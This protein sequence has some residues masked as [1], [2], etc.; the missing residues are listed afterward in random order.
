M[1]SQIPQ[2]V[3]VWRTALLIALVISDSVLSSTSSAHLGHK[4][5]SSSTQSQ[6]VNQ[7]GDMAAVDDRGTEQS[8]F[9]RIANNIRLLQLRGFK[10]SNTS[11]QQL[12]DYANLNT[13]QNGNKIEDLNKKW[14]KNGVRVW[15]KRYHAGEETSSGERN[16]K[17]NKNG[18]RVWGKRHGGEYGQDSKVVDNRGE[19][20]D[21]QM[22]AGTQMKRRE[23]VQNEKKWN[24]N[25]VRVWGK[26]S[27]EDG[28]NIHK[29]WNKYGVRVWG[30][31]NP[32]EVENIEGNALE[33]L[34]ES[35]ETVKK[36]N[37]NGVK[38]WG[39]RTPIDGI[40]KE[41]KEEE[42][43]LQ[44]KQYNQNNMNWDKQAKLNSVV[45]EA[46]KKWN[47]NGVRVWGKR[48]EDI[49]SE[50]KKKR[51]GDKF[52]NLSE[53]AGVSPDQTG[54]IEARLNELGATSSSDKST[55]KDDLSEIQKFASLDEND[56]RLENSKRKWDNNKVRIWGKRNEE[57]MRGL[58]EDNEPLLIK[59]SKDHRRPTDRLISDHVPAA[60]VDQT[61]N[62]N[63]LYR[64][65]TASLMLIA[66]NPVRATNDGG[67]SGVRQVTRGRELDLPTTPSESSLPQLRRR[68]RAWRGDVGWV[69]KRARSV[70]S[71]YNL[72]EGPK[73][74]W[75]T[76]VI[77]VWGKRSG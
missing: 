62:R 4:P 54:D 12:A 9:S 28:S 72:P 38:V 26:R 24:K 2:Q 48:D 59:S 6:A 73:R 53:G 56:I 76:N 18:V 46:I 5:G 47:K 30:K 35:V 67:E 51:S 27:D 66:L 63:A 58:Q 40:E 25:G 16:K 57:E 71:N 45:N 11:P 7:P 74:G 23:D 10:N 37:K 8:E 77:R 64:D 13:A 39:K 49:Y 70:R 68:R 32:L 55:S 31:R 60:A 14:N 65:H 29:K 61:G 44:R 20:D 33:E 69:P 15:G 42:E 34:N 22:R 36:W 17:W 1:T 50:R 21:F 52:G 19:K 43:N 3:D 75:R 41:Q